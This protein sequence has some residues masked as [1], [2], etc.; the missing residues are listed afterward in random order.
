MGGS[1]EVHVWQAQWGSHQ[2]ACR[3]SLFH[4]SFLIHFIRLLWFVWSRSRCLSD[5]PI[6]VNQ[7]C[8]PSRGQDAAGGRWGP[9]GTDRRQSMAVGRAEGWWFSSCSHVFQGGANQW[10]VLTQR[11]SRVLLLVCRQRT[12]ETC[13]VE[14]TE[15]C[16]PCA[17]PGGSLA[18]RVTGFWTSPA[19]DCRSAGPQWARGQAPVAP[20]LLSQLTAAKGLLSFI[21]KN[22]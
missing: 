5:I 15:P 20:V 9:M 3:V 1:N 7:E 2:G 16:F 12:N 4:V 8:S 13:A 21:Y 18:S 11:A 10:C 22:A 17:A 14:R 19:C 6:S